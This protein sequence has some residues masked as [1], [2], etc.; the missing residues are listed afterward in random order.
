[1]YNFNLNWHHYY[2][3]LNLKHRVHDEHTSGSHNHRHCTYEDKRLLEGHG[4][5]LTVRDQMVKSRCMPS[6]LNKL[7]F[8]NNSSTHFEISEPNRDLAANT[9]VPSLSSIFFQVQATFSSQLNTR[10]CSSLLH[11]L[12][13]QHFNDT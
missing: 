7:T 2:C 11:V 8:N 4:L 13:R 9:R 10:L 3:C 12:E 6:K 5:W 1:M